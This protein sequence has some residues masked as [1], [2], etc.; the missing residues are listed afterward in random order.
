MKIAAIIA[1]YNPFHNGHALHLARTCEI[2]GE[3]NIICVMSGNFTQRGEPAIAD[4]WAR[5]RMALLGGADIVIEL[6]FLFAT[7]SAEGFAR[8][9][10][11]LSGALGCVDYLSFGSESGELEQLKTLARILADEPPVFK[12]AVKK[13]LATGVSFP[14]ARDIA[15]KTV[16]DGTADVLT[17]AN[18]IL[19]IEYL[20][21][22]YATKSAVRPIC[23]KREGSAYSELTMAANF[24]SASAIRAEIAAHGMSGMVAANV[25][26]TV[27]KAMDFAP[28][29]GGEYYFRLL[30]YKL[31]SMPL[32]EISA[33]HGVT[34]G[35][36]YRI[37]RAASEAK[38]LDE[39]IFAIKS[40][41]FT[42]TRVMRVLLHCLMGVTD[43][44][45]KK[46][47]SPTYARVLGFKREKQGLL[48][49]LAEC[50]RIPLLTKP[51]EFTGGAAL[52][53]D[54]LASDIYSLLNDA[55]LP[56]SR[57]FTEKLIVV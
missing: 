40:K 50:S 10:V 3:C 39:M 54:I 31:R 22:L 12:E 15:L 30:A 48:S 1:E 20:K 25:P 34:E 45:V 57:D 55:P 46:C 6:P 21:A 14:R 23:V 44:A 26:P 47:P 11:E 4:K 52:G 24:S 2:A 56:A 27:M 49:R 17:G 5:A 16:T 43:D 19:A 35:L 41:R 9:G 33:I 13:A 38:S 7:R 18:N 29:T 42:Y 32:N 8:G 37:A 36:E 53:F 28:L 51:S